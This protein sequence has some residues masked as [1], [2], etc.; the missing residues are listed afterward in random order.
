MGDALT[1]VCS[2]NEQETDT[3][4]GKSYELWKKTYEIQAAVGKLIDILEETGKVV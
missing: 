2:M 1:T 4:K 3:F